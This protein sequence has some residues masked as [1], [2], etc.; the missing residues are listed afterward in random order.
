M[1][2]LV[3][4]ALLTL[5]IT[6]SAYCTDVLWYTIDSGSKLDMPNEGIVDLTG[7]IGLADCN[8][9]RQIKANDSKTQYMVHAIKYDNMPEALQPQIPPGPSSLM[10]YETSVGR[11]GYTFMTAYRDGGM[12]SFAAFLRQQL[13]G[14]YGSEAVVSHRELSLDYKQKSTVTYRDKLQVCPDAFTLHLLLKDV[15]M[16]YQPETR[17]LPDGRQITVANSNEHKDVD[18][19]YVTIMATAIPDSLEK[20]G[21][22]VDHRLKFHKKADAHMQELMERK[23]AENAARTLELRSQA[24]KRAQTAQQNLQPQNNDPNHPVSARELQI[25]GKSQARAKRLKASEPAQ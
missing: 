12:H 21:D 22:D 10:I 16:I 11:P 2:K 23:A 15:R 9:G 17:T 5:I 25:T 13:E 3:T 8:E 19:G 7:R 4:A 14:D 24:E 18:V 20:I 1:K 6:S